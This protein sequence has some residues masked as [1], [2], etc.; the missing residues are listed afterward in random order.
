M[1]TNKADQTSYCLPRVRMRFAI[2]LATVL[3]ATSLSVTSIAHAQDREFPAGS[4]VVPMDLSYQD[5]GLLQAY[6]LV[7]QLLRQGVTVHWVIDP[8]KT[9]HAAP[10]N[11]VGDECTWSCDEEASGVRC[12][13]PTASPDFFVGATVLWSD[14]GMAAGATITR[15][16]YRG[17]PFVI[18]AA[19]ADRARPIID[20]WNDMTTWTAS[21]WARRTVFHVVTVH[22][23]TE[24]FTG[25]V[26]K[27]M[28]A[29]PTIAVFSDGNED[30]ATGYLRAAGIPQSSGVEFPAGR[31][32]AD[33]CGPGT[34]N[35]D[36]LTVESIM[37]EM[38]TCEAPDTDHRNGALFT[39]D[40]APAY[41]QIMSMHWA[42]ADRETVRCDGG[43]CPATQAECSGET[44]TYHGHEVVAEVREFL[45]FPTHFFAEC[46]AV[47]AYE[48]TVP[49][50]DWPY[51]DDDGRNGHFLTTTG[52]PP[53]CP[54]TDGD[55]ECV[56]GGCDDGTRDCCQPRALTEV[57]AGFLIAPQPSSDELQILHPDV[58]Y[59]QMD[60]AW[61]TVGGSE[62]AYNLSSYLGTT[63]SGDADVTFVTGPDGP[64]AEDVWMTGYVDGV[65]DIGSE[66]VDPDECN[67]G[68]VS[69]LGG[70]RY[71]TS[72]PLS[73]NEDAQ[74]TRMFLNA[75]FE[76]DCV[77]SAAQPS[78]SLL[79]GGS[80]LVPS[81]TLPADEAYT[82]RTSNGG[83]GA[84][85]DA[86]LTV[87]I[88]DALTI[89]TSDAGGT[90][91]GNAVT[92]EL[93]SIG[94]SGSSTPPATQ[95][96][97]LTLRFAST[98]EHTLEASVT[99]RVGVSERTETASYVV[100]V[101]ADRDG[102]GIADDADPFPDDAMRCGDSDSDTCDDCAVAGTS[103]PANDGPDADGDGTC[104]AGEG[105]GG[106]RDG[107][108]SP[109][110]SS[111]GCGCRATGSGSLPSFGIVIAIAA[112]VRARRRRGAR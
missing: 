105:D 3:S 103:S 93:G 99:Y 14:E 18:D 78:I 36:M 2:V 85:L 67:L 6:G 51:L 42:V 107:G 16:G 104:D 8:D 47:N 82:I 24:A 80:R 88:P 77:T 34:A 39:D 40:G 91:A 46:Q 74:G 87:T 83:R 17:G 96:R 1:T 81:S 20:A 100:M 98:G 26:R 31:C 63:Y 65:C 59:N 10:C 15:H 27:E 89:T 54:C 48:N 70:H 109:G 5:T 79:W 112:L 33:A 25:F 73:A 101:A 102:D 62:P 43:A 97:G 35:P 12:P 53:S 11:T 50:P 21:P 38:G 13:Y 66:F 57:G 75:L 95:M 29:A 90:V 68:K 23:T 44:F 108:T 9:W 52:T 106:G 58:P 49:N 72:T 55:F 84:A 28:I 71:S 22:Q 60:G 94:A 69:Y 111:G 86:V 61:Q 4:L 19:D 110:G 76:A 56:V 45:T 7:F 30:I 37:G 92:W 41:C 32:A 64:G